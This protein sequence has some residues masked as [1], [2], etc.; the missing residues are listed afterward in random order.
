MFSIFRLQVLR[1]TKPIQIGLGLGCDLKMTSLWYPHIHVMR[2][3]ADESLETIQCFKLFLIVQ[4]VSNDIILNSLGSI[5]LSLQFQ[6]LHI[7]WIQPN[8][9]CQKYCTFPGRENSKPGLQ[10]ERFRPVSK[11]ADQRT[12]SRSDLNQTKPK[13]MC[14]VTC[15]L[16]CHCSVPTGIQTDKRYFTKCTI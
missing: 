13:K 12:I 14:Q 1:V 6:F 7:N 15:S 11:W 16:A 2:Y 4:I 9:V 8:H 10:L 3:K 5:S